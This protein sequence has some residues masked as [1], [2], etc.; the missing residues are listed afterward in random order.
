FL[1]WIELGT[2]HLLGRI[3]VRLELGPRDW[4][5]DRLARTLGDEPLLIFAQQNVGVDERAATESAGDQ[6]FH[7]AER[8]DVEH[9]VKALVRIPEILLQAV[10]RAGKRIRRVRL[11]A[12]EH[13]DA[14]PG[15]GQPIRHH[16]AAESRADDDGV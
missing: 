12:L 13:A 14:H 6:S 1:I 7:P 2:E 10:W 16:G 8:P 5:R 11:S 15:F 3:V 9:A 4:P